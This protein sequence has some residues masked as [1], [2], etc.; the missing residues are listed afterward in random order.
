MLEWS[1]AGVIVWDLDHVDGTYTV[2][3]AY[4]TSLDHDRT[5]VHTHHA[6]HPSNWAEFYGQNKLSL[7]TDFSVYEL[8]NGKLEVY[9]MKRVA[10]A[11]ISRLLDFLSLRNVKTIES[12]IA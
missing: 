1:T 12:T 8:K 6:P 7:V 11:L 2:Y 3:E 9:A 5:T 4:G 10:A